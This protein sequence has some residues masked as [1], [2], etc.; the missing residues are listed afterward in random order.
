MPIR[1][2]HRLRLEVH[3]DRR[4][5]HA[6]IQTRRPLVG[7]AAHARRIVRV[8][9]QDRPERVEGQGS[10]ARGPRLQPVESERAVRHQPLPDVAAGEPL[11][12]EMVRVQQQP[13]GRKGQEQ[14][15]EVAGRA[16]DVDGE[17]IGVRDQIVGR[18]RSEPTLQHG[19]GVGDGL[20]IQ[21]PAQGDVIRDA[22]LAA[23]R[24]AD[25]RVRDQP[26]A[27]GV[28]P[29]LGQQSRLDDRHEVGTLVLL[30][31][32][33][34]AGVRGVQQPVPVLSDQ[35]VAVG[36]ALGRDGERRALPHA[37]GVAR[38]LACFR[39]EHDLG[40]YVDRE[41]VDVVEPRS[42]GDAPDLLEVAR[43]EA[44]D[45]RLVGARLGRDRVPAP[46]RV[47]GEHLAVGVDRT[48]DQI[49]RLL[50][51]G[52]PALARSAL[53]LDMGE[54]AHGTLAA[55]SRQVATQ[56]SSW[57]STKS[58]NPSSNSIRYGRPMI[59]GCIVRMKAP[60]RR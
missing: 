59:C 57:P 45:R 2:P 28:H 43:L 17:P 41:H 51:V 33:H 18:R 7:M 1:Q 48:V 5:R 27:A 39:G 21:H 34:D 58:M 44:L 13:V 16:L 23:I 26:D 12:S 11:R 40:A 25:E 19:V 38:H 56:T 20:G 10:F 60:P 47:G 53:D 6:L 32:E 42:F 3:Q 50:A 30:H 31:L 55:I 22:R 4:H 36:A 49:A 46:V 15:I 14:P 37:A 52:P 24:V 54:R 9:G 8:I 35:R 29:G